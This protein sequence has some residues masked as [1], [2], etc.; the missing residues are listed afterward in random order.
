VRRFF[1][2]LSLI[3]VLTGAPR[4]ASADA[5]LW[6]R[7]RDPEL[8]RSE[9]LADKLERLIIMGEASRSPG[10][11]RDFALAAVAA[12]DLAGANRLPGARLKC[13]L[14]DVLLQADFPRRA[15]ELLA[16][17]VDE[18]PAG[19][20]SASCYYTYGLSLAHL[21]E[22]RREI[23]A[24]TRALANAER[25]RLRA[26]LF[27][28]RGDARVREGELALA[29][30]D[31]RS[32]IALSTH[33]DTTALSYYGLAVALDRYGDLPA[34]WAALESA[35]RVAQPF[36]GLPGGD[37]LDAPGVF[38]VPPYEKEYYRALSRMA[39]A[40]SATS[41]P[42]RR[43][44]TERALE[45]WE[46]FIAVAEPANDRYLENARLHALACRRELER[47]TR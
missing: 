13:L 3:G 17:V 21:G 22:T 16:D 24:Y 25:R 10:V 29:I 43:E 40:R 1:V 8:V 34:A 41:E 46:A 9:A 30:D 26:D 38:F 31:Y 33:P 5:N 11:A 27:Y 4:M 2:S 32:A 45:H 12:A 42:E 7:A 37:I 18:L 28:N 44:H 15:R 47:K 39:A 6:Q 20:L 14:G 35:H 23:V 19:P 36:T